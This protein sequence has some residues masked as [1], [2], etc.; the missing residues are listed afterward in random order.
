MDIINAT[1][2]PA[3]TI[4]STGSG[5]GK[6]TIVCALLAALKRRGLRLRAFKCGPD[7]IDP[8]FH[9]RALGVPSKNLDLYF[10]NETQTCELFA[11]DNDAE[12]SLIEGVMGLYDGYDPHSASGST[13][14]LAQ[15][16]RTPIALIVDARG[17]GRSLLAEIRGFMSMDESKLI[18]CVILDRVSASYYAMM[19]PIVEQE[20]GID[21]PGYFPVADESALESRYLGL[22]LPDE[23]ADLRARIDRAADAIAKTVD[24]DALI[25]LA[26]RRSQLILPS[27]PFRTPRITND[28]RIAAA[29]LSTTS[30]ND[31]RERP[32]IAVAQDAAFCFYY[33]DNLR[34]LREFGA[35][36]VPFSP[37]ADAAFP[38]DVDGALLGGGY[39]ELY[40]ETLANNVSML[41]SFRNAFN[42]GLPCLAE[43]GGFMW[44][45][46]AIT[47]QDGK[48]YAMV[49]ALR[50]ECRYT[51]K[52]VRF[53]Y[54]E[55]AERVPTFFSERKSIRG[56]E[57]HYYES[58][59]PG[60]SCVAVKPS[61]KKWDCA[62]VDRARWLG[63]AH[64]YYPSAPEFAQTFVQRC[65]EYRGARKVR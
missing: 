26:K 44:L 6:T 28:E 5:R 47:V 24:L 2:L 4:A 30:A 20:L 60:D 61:G 34:L 19:K 56:H 35:E 18:S 50:G 7:Y 62:F 12:L 39:P 1:D 65:A 58:D 46:E 57:F 55:L 54:A 21:V 27:D 17:M 16:L 32:R 13:Y 52:L 43:C 23:I 9:Q 36:L 40:A 10:T 53:G 63:F 51:G 45:H 15:A 8:L 42:K 49:G 22:K 31:R 41:T 3:L 48:R 38:E 14:A 37:L 11:L 33:A 29:R 64:L 25:A 59:F